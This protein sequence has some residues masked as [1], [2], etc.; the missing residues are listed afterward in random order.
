[1][2]LMNLPQISIDKTKIK[3]KTDNKIKIILTNFLYI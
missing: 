3:I 2:T 1:M